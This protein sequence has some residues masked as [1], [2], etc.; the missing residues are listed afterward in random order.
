MQ[1]LVL[2][3]YALPKGW[4]GITR[5]G[6]LGA[7]LVQRG[8]GVT[9]IAS[10]FDYL[11]RQRRDGL[12]KRSRHDGVQFVWLRT[13]TYTG[14]DAARVRSMVRFSTAAAWA[15]IHVRPRPDVIIGSSP[16]LLTGLSA[17]A[18]ARLLRRPW[19]F[20]V[21]D[22]WPSSLV[23]LGGLREGGRT[24]R[25]LLR[26]EG[27]LYRSAD[28]VVTVPPSGCLRLK[29]LGIASKHCVHIPNAASTPVDQPVLSERT[30]DNFR[31]GVFTLMY[32][33]AHGVANQLDNVIEAATILREEHPTQYQRLRIELIGDGQERQRL[34]ELAT[35]RGLSNVR[36]SQPRAKAEIS[37]LL[38]GADACLVHLSAA[39]VFRYGVS[40][41]KLFDYFA[42][43]K[44]VLISSKHP[45]IVDE[46]GAGIRFRPGVPG[47]L[48]KG[49]IRMMEMDRSERA[50]MGARGLELARTR[51]SVP[52]ITDQYETLLRE[53][54]SQSPR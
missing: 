54:V 23:D 1:I 4:A 12:D 40:P 18:V 30:P 51:Y 7:E 39:D 19:V 50:A 25:G 46:A 10:D 31:D 53:A 36:F 28:R 8:H 42:A 17:W 3:Q 45:T 49:I 22:F 27:A 26:L 6:D 14:N 33:G 24:H 41:N 35:D 11:K 44:P 37:R 34:S 29:E 16:H 32:T 13:G 21:R 52:T 2:N 47:D 43:G 48:A 5:H 9:V 20:E 38:E 15:A